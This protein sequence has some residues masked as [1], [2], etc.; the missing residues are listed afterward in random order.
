MKEDAEKERRRTEFVEGKKEE[1]EK[2]KKKRGVMN[3]RG[4]K[5]DDQP[6]LTTME[7]F[8]RD[9]TLITKKWH[10]NDTRNEMDGQFLSP[11]SDSDQ[12][13][14]TDGEKRKKKESSGGFTPSRRNVG[15]SEMSNEVSQSL[16][17]MDDER[18]EDGVEQ[19]EEEE[20]EEDN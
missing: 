12:N 13:G 19:E 18:R 11:L 1:E 4:D 17:D 16:T 20:Y 2:K 9:L 14:K 15:R 10:V 5:A 6:A 7:K 3:R 8:E